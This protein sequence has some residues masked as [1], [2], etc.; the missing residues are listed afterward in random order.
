MEKYDYLIVGAGFAGLVLA[1]R[2]ATQTGASCLVV[3]RRRHLEGNAHDEYDRAGVLVHK[4]R[5]HYFLAKCGRR[6]RR[7][8]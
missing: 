7:V 2:L 6:C 3:D 4:Y 8:T 5:P 1:E